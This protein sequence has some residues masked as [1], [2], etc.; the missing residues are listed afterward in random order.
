MPLPHTCGPK[1]DEQCVP[2]GSPPKLA[3]TKNEIPLKLEDK[4]DVLQLQKDVQNSELAAFQISQ[5]LDT[6]N[7]GTTAKGAVLDKKINA[8]RKTYGLPDDAAFD[9]DKLAFTTPEKK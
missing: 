2:G 5:Q 9:P 8:L 3:D 4:A 1:G 6:A 7:K